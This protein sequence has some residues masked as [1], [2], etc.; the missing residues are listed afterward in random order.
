MSSIKGLFVNY[1]YLIPI[2]LN[3]SN[4]SGIFRLFTASIRN[5]NLLEIN[6]RSGTPYLFGKNQAIKW[7]V[8]PLMKEKSKFPK[9]PSEDFL[10][11][12]LAM[13]LGL[14]DFYFELQVQRQ[15]DPQK[16]PIE[17]SSVNWKTPF[18]KVAT[19]KILKQDFN[20]NTMLEQERS[21]K[22]TPWNCIDDH[23]PLGG[24]NRLRKKIYE[25]MSA[26]R[27]KIGK[28]QE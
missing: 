7:L 3:P 6:Y 19:I 26:L 4:W 18:T 10:R 24:N 21:I 25:E 13:D 15:N 14:K 8:T 27:N 5:S 16:E 17:D 9:Q 23:R 11:K 20:C 28:N 22:F 2:F 12:R 1:L